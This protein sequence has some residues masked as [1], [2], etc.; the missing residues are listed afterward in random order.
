[1]WFVIRGNGEGFKLGHGTE[2]HIR[3][4]RQV[5]GLTGK[6]IASLS[7]GSHHC[8]A[9]TEDGEMLSWG[10]NDK[11]QLGEGHTGLKPEPGPAT[12]L[13]GKCIMGTACSAAQVGGLVME[14]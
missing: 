4:P 5:E 1:M 11:G 7:L 9:T 10:R 8:L 14:S 13:I 2:D 6:H 3:I 12:A